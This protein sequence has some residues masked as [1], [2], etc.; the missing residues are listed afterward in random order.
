[1]KKNSQNSRSP[2]K[3]KLNSEDRAKKLERMKRLNT[4]R[5]QRSHES[6]DKLAR[7][8]EDAKILV[9]KTAGEVSNLVSGNPLENILSK[10]DMAEYR[11][12]LRTWNRDIEHY[13]NKLI[14][15]SKEH[16]GKSGLVQSDDE[17]V[18]C[19]GLFESYAMFTT[20]FTTVITPLIHSIFR[21]L[22]NASITATNPS[23]SVNEEKGNDDENTDSNNIIIEGENHD[24]KGDK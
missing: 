12:A 22:N 19:I 2:K 7:T 8:S 5:G 14:E 13:V 23:A 17:F 21:Y 18:K 16:E 9:V 10:E 15:I 6:W 24:E 3:S 4:V 1:M 11:Q 20:E